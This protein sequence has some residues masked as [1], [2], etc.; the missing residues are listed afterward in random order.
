MPPALIDLIAAGASIAGLAG[1]VIE[2]LPGCMRPLLERSSG[3]SSA[4]VM[5]ACQAELDRVYQPLPGWLCRPASSKAG[6]PLR[7]SRVH[8]PDA[9]RVGLARRIQGHR[10]F[11][12][13]A[14]FSWL[15]QPVSAVVPLNLKAEIKPPRETWQP[16]RA[17][18]RRLGMKQTKLFS[19]LPAD[20]GL[21]RPA[22]AEALSRRDGQ[23]ARSLRHS[24]VVAVNQIL[25]ESPPCFSRRAG[26]GGGTV[27][28]TGN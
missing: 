21:P 18:Q 5:S 12:D 2:I 10:W 17:L 24:H 20:L 7:T 23:Y 19:S 4:Q 11:S 27:P 25:G 8:A 13:L 9:F 1:I 26:N 28:W 6:V 3:R 15:V 14:C 16:L 22:P